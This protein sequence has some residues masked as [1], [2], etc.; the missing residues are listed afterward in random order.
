MI[1]VL[2]VEDQ[3]LIAKAIL[4]SL[5][6]HG[7]DVIAV[8]RS[9]EEAIGLSISKK[10]DLILMDIK[11]AGKIDGIEAAK[12]INEHQPTVIIYLTDHAD[13]RVVDR[14]KETFPANFLAKPFD[15][16]TLIRAIEIAINN[17]NAQILSRAV[18]SDFIFVRTAAQ[19]YLRVD[20]K[21]IIYI[22]ADRSYCKIVAETGKFTLPSNMS[23]VIDQLDTT[24]FIRIHRSYCVNIDKIQSIQGNEVMLGNTRLPIGQ[25]FRTALESKLKFLH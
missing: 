7:M 6:T 9:G 25:S 18:K 3:L 5:T 1:R 8:C 14:A 22:E 11:L 24:R 13:K 20:F 19:Q 17:A 21:D 15:E 4:A 23:H 10:P 16:S 2:V 12:S